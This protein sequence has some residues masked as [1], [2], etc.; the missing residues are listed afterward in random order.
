MINLG[1]YTL[2]VTGFPR[3]GTSVMMRMLAF[4]GIEI[5]A[6]DKL[7]QP[8]HKHDPYGCL[9]LDD[10]GTEIKGSDISWTANKAVKLV[11]PYMEWLPIDR[12][13]KAIFMQ[14]DL[15]EIV[16][17]L[18]AMKTVWEIDIADSLA[19][20]RGYLEYN[21][22]PTLFVKYADVVKYPKST[23]LRVQDFLGA[24]LNIEEMVK[25]VDKEARNRYKKVPEIV[26]SDRP[27]TIIRM[28]KEGYEDLN[29]EVYRQPLAG[30]IR[31]EQP[32]RTS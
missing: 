14:R 17:S 9:E 23:A 24:E 3:S 20:A 22:V 19:W 15:N 8:Q 12:P 6:S 4:A 18:L 16:T 5:L 27:D 30:E 2:I 11:T 28:D 1:G 26:G 31:D 32:L 21:K 7:K 29:V 25:S 13:L 10:V